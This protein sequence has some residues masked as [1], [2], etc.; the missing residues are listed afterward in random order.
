MPGRRRFLAGAGALLAL[1]GVA[2]AADEIFVISRE[3]ILREVRAAQGLR[4]VETR[5][6]TRLQILIDE[7]KAEL[8]AEEAEITRLRPEMSPED[9][10]R[11]AADFD[12]R[13]RLTRRIAQERAAALQKGFQE[14]RAAIVAAVPGIIDRV[15]IE[16]G[17][18]LILNSDMVIVVDPALDLT[19]RVIELVNQ[20]LPEPPVPDIDVSGPILVPPGETVNSGGDARE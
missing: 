16:S 12:R 13:V 1:G 4:E 17:A 10:E 11:R 5:M 14:A 15:R 2:R 20:K 9:F 7:A 19:D 3:R 6:T 8:A 18:R